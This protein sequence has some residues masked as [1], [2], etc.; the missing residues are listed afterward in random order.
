MEGSTALF[1]E[2]I[3]YPKSGRL[4]KILTSRNHNI[5][6]GM[7]FMN[8]KSGLLISRASPQHNSGNKNSSYHRKTSSRG[9]W[10]FIRANCL[11]IFKLLHKIVNWHRSHNTPN[12]ISV[13]SELTF[14]DTYWSMG[15]R[16]KLFSLQWIQCVYG[17]IVW[18][19]CWSWGA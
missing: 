5:C 16:L 12:T 14:I 18:S 13:L 11:I 19:L 4:Q 17:S 15:S 8:P 7:P 1:W 10:L 3:I 9:S 6:L 2:D